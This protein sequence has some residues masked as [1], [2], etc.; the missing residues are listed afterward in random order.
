VPSL[1]TSPEGPNLISKL[2]N[3]GGADSSHS[4]CVTPHAGPLPGERESRRTVGREPGTPNL[5]R[6]AIGPGGFPT[7]EAGAIRIHFSAVA[8]FLLSTWR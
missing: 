5:R 6:V 3:E 2:A 8:D 4:A 1:N 7:S